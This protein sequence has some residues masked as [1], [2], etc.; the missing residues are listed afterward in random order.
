MLTTIY[1][2]IMNNC[3]NYITIGLGLSLIKYYRDLRMIKE[4]NESIFTTSQGTI[5]FSILYPLELL[6]FILLYPVV[7][8]MFA[9]AKFSEWE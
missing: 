5:G 3:E 1:G 6:I 4:H 8:L 9:I 7:F 2:F